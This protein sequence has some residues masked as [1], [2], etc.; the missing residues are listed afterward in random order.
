MPEPEED[1]SLSQDAFIGDEEPVLL[2]REDYYAYGVTKG[3]RKPWIGAS[4]NLLAERRRLAI[5]EEDGEPVPGIIRERYGRAA[6]VE[7][8]PKPDFDDNS[9]WSA[10]Q[11]RSLGSIVVV[12]SLQ[13]FLRE[14]DEHVDSG[15][16]HEDEVLPHTV[17]VRKIK[18]AA[19]QRVT[20]GMVE[21]WRGM[22]HDTLGSDEEQP[23]LDK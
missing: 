13:Q 15:K 4:W 6:P 14:I 12:P 1:A 22:V 16:L 21:L 5:Q 23:K 2:G 8:D 11:V 17:V 9:Y 3:H 10:D 19:G 18:E 7:F 20:P